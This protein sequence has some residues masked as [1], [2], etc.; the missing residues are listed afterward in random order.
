MHTNVGLGC[1]GCCPSCC[2]LKYTCRQHGHLLRACELLTTV[3]PALSLGQRRLCLQATTATLNVYTCA[4]AC[5][6]A[7]LPGTQM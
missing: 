1:C 3:V 4:C 7:A 2:P 5:V 6:L